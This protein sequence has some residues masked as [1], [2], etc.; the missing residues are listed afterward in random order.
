[1][2]CLVIQKRRS[3]GILSVAVSVHFLRESRE[4]KRDKRID[5]RIGYFVGLLSKQ[6]MLEWNQFF[7]CEI[8]SI[9]G[10]SFWTE[11]VKKGIVQ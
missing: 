7:K 1:M 9:G 11:R 5:K 10:H 4:E 8:L 6:N 2:N 3:N